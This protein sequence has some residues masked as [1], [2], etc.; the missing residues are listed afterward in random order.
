MKS[1][2]LSINKEGV[3]E[4]TNTTLRA[5]EERKILFPLS[6]PT[7]S[8]SYKGKIIV[9][10][11]LPKHKYR[12]VVEKTLEYHFDILSEDVKDIQNKQ[13]IINMIELGK[14]ELPKTQIE[15]IRVISCDDSQELSI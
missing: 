11:D 9:E 1:Y 8:I 2:A 10:K 5:S 7:T 14:Y 4:S 12:I 3:R 6:Y 13:Q 15:H